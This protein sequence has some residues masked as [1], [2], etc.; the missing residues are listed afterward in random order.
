[1]ETTNIIE[2]PQPQVI[3]ESKE[4]KVKAPKILE[5]LTK[6]SKINGKYDADNDTIEMV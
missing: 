1:M 6:L 3:L 2:D 4:L 5:A